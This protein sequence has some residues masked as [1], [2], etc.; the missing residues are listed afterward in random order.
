ML[1]AVQVQQYNFGTVDEFGLREK[2]LGAYSLGLQLYL[3]RQI[4]K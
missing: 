2:Y 4:A 3:I 1:E